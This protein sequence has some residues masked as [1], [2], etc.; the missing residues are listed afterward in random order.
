MQ[1]TWYTVPG[2][3]KNGH[4]TLT[5]LHER[6][7]HSAKGIDSEGKRGPWPRFEEG[8]DMN[9]GMHFGHTEAANLE[10]RRDWRLEGKAGGHI[11]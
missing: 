9:R 8:G 5:Q 10:W 1:P 6:M 7:G 2:E 3:L 11:S 4:A